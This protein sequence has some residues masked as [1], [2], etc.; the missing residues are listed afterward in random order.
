[1]QLIQSV[2]LARETASW[3]EHRGVC[4]PTDS[5]EVFPGHRDSSQGRA[6]GD[7][8]GEE[9]HYLSTLVSLTMDIPLT[10]KGNKKHTFWKGKN[11]TLLV[12]R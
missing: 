10:K 9:R 4:R 11:E 1:M 7:W 6:P 2:L 3:G 5:V 8:E 12:G